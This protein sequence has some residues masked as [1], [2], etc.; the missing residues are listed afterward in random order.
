[1]KSHSVTLSL[2]TITASTCALTDPG[3][4]ASR[5]TH[6]VRRGRRADCGAE[7][8]ILITSKA[9]MR[10]QQKPHHNAASIFVENNA[11]VARRQ[12][13]IQVTSTRMGNSVDLWQM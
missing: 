13:F 8:T 11:P 9:Q 3:C 7:V 1:M 4:S 2:T 10:S 12:P 6:S 5:T